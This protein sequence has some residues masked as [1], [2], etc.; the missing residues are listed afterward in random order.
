M[1]DEVD[2]AGYMD[3]LRD[4]DLLELEAV[5]THQVLDIARRPGQ[6]V[7]EADDLLA[8][9]EEPLATV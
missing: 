8:V 9:I 1:Q 2:L 3:E 5:A 4:V 7:V 6:E